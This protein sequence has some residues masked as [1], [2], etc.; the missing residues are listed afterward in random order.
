MLEA[1]GIVTICI[2]MIPSL[3][4]AYGFPRVAA[5]E[6]PFSLPLGAPHDRTGQQQILHA[7]LEALTESTVPGSV[8]HLPFEWV[9]EAGQFQSA[10]A[11][12]AP[13]G[14]AFLRKE[15]PDLAAVLSQENWSDVAAILNA[16]QRLG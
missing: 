5:L 7:V 16:G 8:V 4:R 13:I 12:P 14:Q 3:S 11:E 2:N 10:P 1:A 9:D 15:I 6:M